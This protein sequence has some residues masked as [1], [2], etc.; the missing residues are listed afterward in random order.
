MTTSFQRSA[1]SLSASSP[2]RLAQESKFS[3]GPK[4][5]LDEKLEYLPQWDDFSEYKLRFEANLK[6]WL[7]GH[8]FVNFSMVNF[9]DTM[10]APGV[11]PNDLQVRSTIGVRF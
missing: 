1:D 5:T 4:L 11:E 2:A 7:N 9:Y 3:L 6:Y 10:P 8:L